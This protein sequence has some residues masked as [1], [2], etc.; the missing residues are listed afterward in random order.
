MPSARS[1][2]SPVEPRS[3]TC[4]RPCT[5]RS[6]PSFSD[7]WEASVIFARPIERRR[8]P[9]ISAP[10]PKASPRWDGSPSSPNRPSSS[11][12]SLAALNSSE[13]GSSRNTRRGCHSPSPLHHVDRC[14][15]RPSVDRLYPSRPKSIRRDRTHVEW[16]QAFYQIFKSL[17]RYVKQYH[18]N[19]LWW[20]RN[21][22]DARELLQ[23]V[24][25]GPGTT[26]SASTSASAPN[27]AMP[28]PPPPLPTLDNGPPAA[29]AAAAKGQPGGD[30]DS[31]FAQLN[32]G[33]AVTSGLRRVD[34]D[35]ITHPNLSVRAR[36]SLP[37][38][39]DSQTSTSSGRK[40]P[41]P[42]GK[43]PKPESMRTMKPAR[44]ELDGN[45]WVIV[46]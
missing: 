20:N 21:G 13:I 34:K 31:V 5:W 7:R 32:Q 37:N 19:G 28:P 39:T 40:S 9:T 44:K 1:S 16:I 23:Q 33:E 41:A 4:N 38:R 10:C 3:P 25:N 26:S 35:D 46:S 6:S 30:M 17:A 8:W 12:V 43:K 29:A 11:R 42:P 36:T 18:L 45:R 15:I 27:G 24:K 22:T 2:S 14:R